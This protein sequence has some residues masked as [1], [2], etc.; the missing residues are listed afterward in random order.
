[1]ALDVAT[2]ARH[3]AGVKNPLVDVWRSLD[4]GR[5]GILTLL[6]VLKIGSEAPNAFKVFV[7]LDEIAGAGDLD[8]HDTGSRSRVAVASR[9][10]VERGANGGG[11][12][13]PAGDAGLGTDA[14][15]IE[16]EV[17]ETPQSQR[18]ERGYGVDA[19]PDRRHGLGQREAAF[20][21]ERRQ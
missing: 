10:V 3:R 7:E 18:G 17:H 2:Q 13:P 15:G 14:T 19:V 9:A 1:M 5:I 6:E 21:I 20:L 12:V 16:V 8:G 11:S 4:D